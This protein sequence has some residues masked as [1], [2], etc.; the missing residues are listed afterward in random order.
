VKALALLVALFGVAHAQPKKAPVDRFAKAAGDAFKSALAADEANDLPT[1]LGLYKKAFAI[2]PHPSTAYNI[3]DILRRQGELTESIQFFEIFL[4]LGPPAKE[5]KAV[6]ATIAKLW[7]TPAV[8]ELRSTAPSDPESVDLASAYV[9]VNGEI[10]KKAGEPAAFD[11]HDN[12]PRIELSVPAGPIQTVDV[13]TPLSFNSVRC[14]LPPGRKSSCEIRMEPRI[15]GSLV[16][17]TNGDR[18][19]MELQLAWQKRVSK[20]RVK[21]PAGKQKLEVRDNNLECGS[22]VTVDVPKGND[23]AYVFIEGQPTSFYQRCRTFKVK[24]HKLTFVD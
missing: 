14:R 11:P 23:V 2:S 1:A 10:V 7:A 22:G 9:L 18:R 3:A 21:A 6:E 13:I 8:L 16:V 17:S 4:A 15:D 20:G 24:Q 19:D 5:A 12:K